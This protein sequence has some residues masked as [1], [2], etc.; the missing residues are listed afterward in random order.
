MILIGSHGPFA[1]GEQDAA[2]ADII[3][4]YL[5]S[6]AFNDGTYYFYK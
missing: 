1:L 4:K 6:I 3:V 2:K 5:R